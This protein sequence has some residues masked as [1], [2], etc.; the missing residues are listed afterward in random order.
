MSL[1]LGWIAVNIWIGLLV[2]MYMCTPGLGGG[3]G[4]LVECNC[5][6]VSKEDTQT[7]VRVHL[8]SFD[9]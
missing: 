5:V 7:I 2:G 9:V 1:R 4:I 8:T 3:R 6:W